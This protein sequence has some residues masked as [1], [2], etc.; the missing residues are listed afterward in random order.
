MKPVTYEDTA[1]PH[2]SRHES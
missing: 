1:R 2:L